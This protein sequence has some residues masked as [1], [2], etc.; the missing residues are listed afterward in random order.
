MDKERKFL[1]NFGLL[2]IGSA[3][4]KIV[5]FL[6]IPLYTSVLST[7]ELGLYELVITTISL[8]IPIITLDIADATLRFSMEKNVDSVDVYSVSTKICVTGILVVTVLLGINHV[9]NSISFLIGNELFFVLLFSGMAEQG[10]LIAFYKGIDRVIDTTIAGIVGTFVI[11]A[12]NIILLVVL[13]WGIKGYFLASAIGI[14]V[15]VVY[16]LYK[17]RNSR[18]RFHW[19]KCGKLELEMILYSLPLIA[20]NVAWWINSALDRYIITYFR[21]VSENGIYSVGYKIPTI[22]NV[23][24]SL[25]Q[26]AWTLSAIQEYETDESVRYFNRMY[27][28]YNFILVIICSLLILFN[29]TIAK[30]MYAKEFYDAWRYVPFLCI[31]FVFLG[32]ANY[33]GG[34]FNAYKMPKAIAYTTILG[35]IINA[36]LNV[37][38]IPHMGAVGAAIATCI[39]YMVIWCARLL[40]ISKQK[41]IS[42]FS[43]RDI[44]SYIVLAF[45][46]LYTVYD[47]SWINV[48]R[49]VMVCVIVFLYFRE[50][51]FATEMAKKVIKKRNQ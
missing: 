29:K 23:T 48:V 14:Q 17:L 15:Q 31:G 3:S 13:H 32:L 22:L 8:A 1:K 28:N 27:K 42:F 45:G 21:G 50:I 30:I 39:S 33:V 7:A 51:C 26:Q 25:F 10:I 2:A 18:I 11:F 9:T 35:A 34:I 47:N 44:F 43:L 24:Q 19:L 41:N 16:L 5:I 6:L 38:L 36:I 40:V 12:L 4:S 37:I 20:N 49:V 46:S